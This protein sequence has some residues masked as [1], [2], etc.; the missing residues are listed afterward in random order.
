MLID[1]NV[2]LY[3]VDASSSLNERAAD[4]LITT[5]RGDRRVAL[6]WATSSAFLRISTHPRVYDRP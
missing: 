4:W 6:P 3:A 1:A 5:L 2:L